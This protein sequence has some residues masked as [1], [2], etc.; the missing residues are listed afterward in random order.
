MQIQFNLNP[1]L[2]KLKLKFILKMSHL[3]YYKYYSGCLKI[4]LITPS[5][6][7]E[8]IDFFRSPWGFNK[9]RKSTIY[10]YDFKEPVSLIH[11]FE[12]KKFILSEILFIF[13]NLFLKDFCSDIY[14]MKLKLS[15][16]K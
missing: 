6:W 3:W 5:T 10:I 7:E 8:H 9:R 2:N 1:V 13:V 11:T 15:N 4:S 12:K 16:I 14:Q